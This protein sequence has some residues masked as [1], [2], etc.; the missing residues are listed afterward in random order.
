M[1]A[2]QRVI[3]NIKKLKELGMSVDEIKD[4]LKKMGLN[5]DDSKELISKAISSD[6]D[7]KQNIKEE[8]VEQNKDT[9]NE[10]IK[11]KKENEELPENLFN[12]NNIDTKDTEKIT[13]NNTFDDN[14]N[15]N[16]E[17]KDNK[18]NNK[19]KNKKSEEIDISKGLGIKELEDLTK[20]EDVSLFSKEI[21]KNEKQ[22][23]VSENN[24]DNKFEIKEE[25][26]SD[27]LKKLES[28][29]SD[30]EK[31]TENK[32][33]ENENYFNNN[34]NNNYNYNNNIDNDNIWQS[35]LI[36]TINSKLTEIENKQKDIEI[37]LKKKIDDEINKYSKIQETNKKLLLNQVSQEVSQEAD[38]IQQISTKQLTQIKIEQAKLNKKVSDVDSGKLELEEAL[39]EFNKTKEDLLDE[40]NKIQNEIKK[41]S[42]TTSVKLNAKMKQINEIL[43]LQSR[44]SQGLIKNTQQAINKQIEE[45]SKFKENVNSQIDPHK[46]YEKLNEIEEFKEQLAHRYENRFNNV[47][48]EF[49]KKAQV[50]FKDELEQELSNIKRIRDEIANKTDPE[51]INRK[52]EE[53]EIFEKHLLNNIDEKISQ[54]LK[55][56]ES[57]IN[58]EFKNKINKLDEY[59]NKVENLLRKIEIGQETLKEINNF[60]DQF[61]AIIDKNI[62]KMNTKMT[63]IDD[64]LKSLEK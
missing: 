5:E 18:E 4:N 22:K 37:Y 31:Q 40:N 48:I 43:T 35:G 57:S 3:E 47:K 8:T 44:I 12:K 39:K 56:Y 59:Y 14:N 7:E 19:I 26:D 27:F 54:S 52:L 6:T 49:L 58:Q 23:Y 41:L 62:E 24:K 20:E 1:I 46:L 15:N 16:N 25:I 51:I 42:A 30:I 63:I 9:K 11:Q 33:K 34:N 29:Y 13:K 17:N 60:K 21:D 32:N 2:D 36:S 53:L 64:K 50:A 38:K 55:I 45:L 61:I 10:N 28:N